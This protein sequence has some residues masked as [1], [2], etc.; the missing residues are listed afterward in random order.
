MYESAVNTALRVF[1]KG[2]GTPPGQLHRVA[3]DI[4]Q[5]GVPFY[6]ENNR[7]AARGHRHAVYVEKIGA[8]Q[9]R[10]DVVVQ[11]QLF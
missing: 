5:I 2:A 11:R 9:P 1:G 4:G 6:F 10:S 8:V 7:R 3:D